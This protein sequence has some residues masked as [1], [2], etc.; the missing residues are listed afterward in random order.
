MNNTFKERHLY[1]SKIKKDQ[2]NF[3]FDKG[4]YVSPFF[5]VKGLYDISF[6]IDEKNIYLYIKYILDKKK[7]FEASY[8][9]KS[10][11][12]N[13]MN[14]LRTFLQIPFKILKLPWEYIFKP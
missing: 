13:E 14:L 1:F 11:D 12:M 10:I 2:T 4:F 3:I 8:Q 6:K 5:E 9:G 7:V